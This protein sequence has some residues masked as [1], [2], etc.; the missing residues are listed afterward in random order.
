MEWNE[1]RFLKNQDLEKLKKLS[2]HL[3]FNMGIENVADF[4]LY[5]NK[6]G[7]EILIVDGVYTFNISLTAR[8]NGR[9]FLKCNCG[10]EI[11]IV[12]KNVRK[13][14]ADVN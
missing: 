2:E 5:C 12:S 6:C 11:G 7:A 13:N 9:F 3:G 8:E 10:N 4:Y 14:Y 1:E